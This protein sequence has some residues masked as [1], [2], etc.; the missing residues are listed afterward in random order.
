MSV[1]A[2]FFYRNIMTAYVCESLGYIKEPDSV[3]DCENFISLKESY[4]VYGLIPV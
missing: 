2:N 4:S 3:Y 1:A